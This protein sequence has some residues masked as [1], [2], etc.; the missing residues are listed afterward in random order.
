LGSLIVKDHPLIQ[1]IHPMDHWNLN[2]AAISFR[3]KIKRYYHATSLALAEIKQQ[4]YDLALDLYPFFPNTIFWL[5][6]A[7]IPCTWFL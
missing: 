1:T 3:E 4:Q 7:G 2:V 6:K 5:W